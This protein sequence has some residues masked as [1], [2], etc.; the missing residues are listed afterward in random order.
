MGRRA[1]EPWFR[2]EDGCYYTTKR[3][4]QIN[5]GPDKGKAWDEFRRVHSTKTVD[6]SQAAAV[7][8]A[9]LGH[10]QQT[11]SRDV[12]R[13]YRI[14]LSSFCRDWGGLK[15]EQLKKHHLTKWMGQR[16]SWSPTTRDEAGGCV[17]TCFQWAEEEDLI[18]KNPFL[19]FR[20]G[21]GRTRRD[22]LL[23]DQEY[24]LLLSKA[25]GDYRKILEVLRLTGARPGEIRK[26]TVTMLDVANS[27]CVLP[28]GQ[29]KT[30]KKTEEPRIIWLCPEALAILRR[31][32]KKH[33]EGHLFRDRFD[34]PFSAF[35]VRDRFQRLRDDCGFGKDVTMYVLRHAYATE[36]L[37]RLDVATV[38]ELMGHKSTTT[39]VK[40]YS[41]LVKKK[42]YML[43]AAKKAVD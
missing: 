19:A 32:A 35:S 39:L 42:G 21:N 27:C 5:L 38:A 37:T 9:F 11:R 17:K 15:V 29:H 40:N 31:Q 22:R 36:A 30:G 33:G 14:F 20:R 25:R 7:C 8:D 18:L 16:D 6:A 12:F 41:H 28:P 23:S 34:K 1:K 2:E 26:L 10:V 13:K 3:G 4:Q 43:D 24:R